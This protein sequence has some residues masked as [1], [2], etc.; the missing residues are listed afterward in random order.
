M[1]SVFNR[2][3]TQ[4]DVH[5]TGEDETRFAKATSNQNQSMR[6]CSCL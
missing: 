3:L 6:Q 4:S 1:G 2:Q 5:Q